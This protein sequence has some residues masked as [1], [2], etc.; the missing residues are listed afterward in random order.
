[1]WQIWMNESA[2]TRRA[3]PDIRPTRE[4]RWRAMRRCA[5]CCQ[6]SAADACR[7]N[8]IDIAA[9]FRLMI[10]FLHFHQM[11]TAAFISIACRFALPFRCSCQHQLIIT[12]AYAALRRHTPRAVAC[13]F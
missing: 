1:M 11:L 13:A 5:H 7:E 12:T 9:V 6:R 2:E 10:F 4:A 8:A 3:A